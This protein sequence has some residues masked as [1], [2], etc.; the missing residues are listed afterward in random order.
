MVRAAGRRSLW[1][2]GERCGVAALRERWAALRPLQ[3]VADWPRPCRA[4]A[5]EAGKAVEA[6]R[7]G[8]GGGGGRAGWRGTEGE[9][10]WE[11]WRVPG[12]LTVAAALAECPS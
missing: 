12:G 1:S 6:V 9:G 10:D 4:A 5:E 7:P 11:S 3:A 2:L 8:P